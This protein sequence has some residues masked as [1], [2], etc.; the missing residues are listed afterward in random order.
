MEIILRET[1]DNLGRRGEVVSVANGYARNYLLPQKLALPVTDAN[2]RQVERE[3]EVA[4]AR[5]ADERRAAQSIGDRIAAVECVIA[6][7]VGETD[8]LYGSVTSAD[9]AECL[10]GQK[11]DLDKRKITLTEPIKALGEYA[12]PVRLHR[13]VTVEL[14]V[15]VVR[16]ARAAEPPPAS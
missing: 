14:T 15:K 8:T 6:R 11:V 3:R 12:V 7:R 9:I 5:E 16:E 4:E 13:D 10:E 1:I 2:R